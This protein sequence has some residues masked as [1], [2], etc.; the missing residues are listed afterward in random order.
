LL[1]EEV[2]TQTRKQKHIKNYRAQR[3]TAP[4]ANMGNSDPMI[5]FVV[6]LVGFIIYLATLVLSVIGFVTSIVSSTPVLILALVVSSAM[7]PWVEYHAPIVNEMEHFMR[8]VVYPGYEAV[9]RP[10]MNAIRRFYNPTVCF[11]DAYQLW[12]YTMVWDV[13]YPTIAEC[14]GLNSAYLFGQFLFQFFNDFVINY[15]AQLE[16]FNGPFN[17]AATC[18]AWRRF[19]LAF[20]VSYCCSCNDLCEFLIKAPFP[21]SPVSG[22]LADP[23][24]C[25]FA[26]DSLNVLMEVLN[27]W[28]TL[29]WDVL[30][31]LVNWT[32]NIN[33]P[34]MYTA[35]LI[36]TNATIHLSN[37]YEAS[38]Q[39][40]WDEFAPFYAFNFSGVFR[41][42]A[43]YASLWF[44]ALNVVWTIIINMDRIIRYPTDRFWATDMR[45]LI[46]D[47]VNVIAAPTQFPVVAVAPTVISVGFNV[48][49][50]YVSTNSSITPLNQPNVNYQRPRMSDSLCLFLNRTLCNP[51]DPS[52]ACFGTTYA[53]YLQG[54]NPC[55][56]TEFG[57]T[58]V[59]DIISAAYETTVHF[60]SWAHFFTYADQ[61]PFTHAARDSIVNGAS[62]LLQVLRFIPQGYGM[63]LQNLLTRAVQWYI[64][65]LDF[66]VHM[67]TGIITL[68]YYLT[69]LPGTD[70]Y[71]TNYTEAITE[72]ARIQATLVDE[73]DPTSFMNSMCYLLNNALPVPPIPCT[74]CRVT[75]FLPVN[76]SFSIP[77]QGSTA[78]RKRHDTV[79]AMLGMPRELRDQ[80]HR[81][82]PLIHYGRDYPTNPWDIGHMLWLNSK[83]LMANG[84]LPFPTHDTINRYFD[85]KRAAIAERWNRV[86]RCKEA[87]RVEWTLHEQRPHEWMAR[88]QRGDFKCDPDESVHETRTQF[89]YVDYIPG[90][91]PLIYENCTSPVPP[92]YDFCCFPRSL[93]QAYVSVITLIANSVNGIIQY[94]P[95]FQLPVPTTSEFPYF[96]GELCRAPWNQAC[97]QTDIINAATRVFRVYYCVCNFVTLM[98]PIV[99]RGREQPRICETILALANFAASAVQVATNTLMCV[100]LGGTDSPQQYAYFARGLFNNDIN[101]LADYADEV[102][103]RVADL[104]RDV[105][106]FVNADNIDT[107]CAPSVV[108]VTIVETMRLIS[109]SIA[110]LGTMF[111][112]TAQSNTNLPAECWFRLD[113]TKG[114]PGTLDQIGIIRQFDIVLDV[115]LPDTATQ[116]CRKSCNGADPGIGGITTCVCQVVNTLLPWRNDPNKPISCQAPLNCMD[117]DFCCP[118][119]K[120]GIALKSI[121][122]F[123][124]RALVA[125]IQPWYDGFPQF[126]TNYIFCSES[127]HDPFNPGANTT[128]TECEVDNQFAP[129]ISKC[130]QTNG[131]TVPCGTFTCAKMDIIIENL[132]N[133]TNGLFACACQYLQILDSL[134]SYYFQL[135]SNN[136]GDCFCGTQYGLIPGALNVLRQIARAALDMIRKSTLACY[137]KPSN[138]VYTFNAVT[139]LC[140]PAAVSNLYDPTNSFIFRILSPIANA[141]CI[142]AGN[143]MCVVNS[144]FFLSPL[145]VEPGARAAGG[146][147]GWMF[148]VFFRLFAFVE[149]FVAQFADEQETCTGEDSTCSSTYGTAIFDDTVGA[150]V[151][152]SILTP[153]LTLPLD[154][155]MADSQIACTTICPRGSSYLKVQPNPCQCYDVAHS[156]RGRYVVSTSPV[157]VTGSVWEPIR[158]FDISGTVFNST[159]RT[160]AIAQ[161]SDITYINRNRYFPDYATYMQDPTFWKIAKP[162]VN[163]S[164]Y[165]CRS[166]QYPDA[167]VV[168]KSSWWSPQYLWNAT[169]GGA[170]VYLPPCIN[171]ADWAWAETGRGVDPRRRSTCNKN[172]LCRPDTLPTCGLSQEDMNSS[173]EEKARD[174]IRALDGIIMSIIRF[175]SCAVSTLTNQQPGEEDFGGP[176]EFSG[177]TSNFLYPFEVFISMAW[178]ILAGFIDVTVA[179]IIFLLSF[180]LAFG[181]DNCE[182]Y[183]STDITQIIQGADAITVTRPDLSTYT[184]TNNGVVGSVIVVG[185]VDYC[186]TCPLGGTK[187]CGCWDSATSIDTKG[188]MPCADHCP[189]YTGSVANCVA[190]LTKLLVT[191][192]NGDATLQALIVPPNS[193]ITD[194]C[195]G[196]RDLGATPVINASQYEFPMYGKSAFCPNPQCGWGANGSVSPIEPVQRPGY[197]Y[198]QDATLDKGPYCC[199]CNYYNAGSQDNKFFQC[200][201]FGIVSAFLD[202]IR[203]FVSIFTRQ[204]WIPDGYAKRDT[205]QNMTFTG[206][207]KRRESW[208][209]MTCRTGIKNRMNHRS[210]EPTDNFM[211]I[212]YEYDT[213]DCFDDPTA[214]ACRNLYLPEICQWHNNAVVVLKDRPRRARTPVDPASGIPAD[215]ITQVI[216]D[217][218]TG[219]SLCDHIARDMAGN[220]WANTSYHH[221]IQ[222]V[223][224]LDQ[225]IQ[226]ERISALRPDI[227]PT[228]VIYARNAPFVIFNNIRNSVVHHY[229][230]RHDR[231]RFKRK[232]ARQNRAATHKFA[233]LRQDVK[234]RRAIMAHALKEQL[235]HDSP[236]FQSLL[237]LDSI[238]YKY[239]RGYY[240]YLYDKLVKRIEKRQISFPTVIEAKAHLDNTI[241]EFTRTVSL[242]PYRELFTA[243]VNS[244][245]IAGHTVRDALVAGPVQ[246]VRDAYASVTT[247]LYVSA[248]RRRDAKNAVIQRYLDQTPLYA[249]IT[250][251]TPPA[252]PAAQG[253]SFTRFRTHLNRVIEH[254]RNES[255]RAQLS[256]WNADLHVS[257]WKQHVTHMFTPQL[258]PY[259]TANWHKLKRVGY[260]MYNIVFPGSLTR[261]QHERFIFGSTCILLQRTEQVTVALLSYCVNEFAN[262]VNVTANGRLLNFA[263]SMVEHNENTFHHKRN[264][265]RYELITPTDPHAWSRYRF[266]DS[267]VQRER[268]PRHSID[269][270]VI[271]RTIQPPQQ[272]GPAN[273]NFYTWIWILLQDFISATFGIPA[274]TFLDDVRNWLLNPKTAEADYPNVGLRYWTVFWFR[275]RW[276]DNLNCSKGIGILPAFW[277]VTLGVAIAVFFG[278]RIVP[279][280]LWIVAIFG[281]FFLWIM[282][283]GAVGIHYSPACLRLYPNFNDFDGMPLGS[284]GLGFNM[285]LPMCLADAVMNLTDTY[286]TNCYSPLIIP[287]YMISG[288]LCPTSSDQYIDFISCKTV[289]VSDGI[290]NVLYICYTYLGG[291]AL[292]VITAIANVTI[293]LF[294][295]GVN[296]YFQLTI[297]GFRTASAVQQQREWFCFF[298]TLP[299]IALPGVFV[300]LGGCFIGF[301]LPF[302]L[303]L[304]FQIWSLLETTPVVNALPG[305]DGSFDEDDVDLVPIDF[306][307]VPREAITAESVARWI[308]FQNSQAEVGLYRF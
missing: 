241:E 81:V 271:K 300:F 156:T 72:F 158:V 87:K 151:L 260:Q 202:L 232:L 173:P 7:L 308:R 185:A 120:A 172:G 145:C 170:G 238:A 226:G 295:P 117:I 103:D 272:D 39:L 114:C 168:A 266:I 1:P 56:L 252:A 195:Q 251:S 288:P 213:T 36:A 292:D 8:T 68:P 191:N 276:P 237:G 163:V 64:S 144:L 229:T 69:T 119:V 70:N 296:T 291:W 284:L 43:D 285:A 278:S 178:Q 282:L 289:G 184:Y 59:S 177:G 262:N 174:P 254:N 63:A 298:F 71:A 259:K 180:L 214:C 258:T 83:D 35:T 166:I 92:C 206:P 141:M 13:I 196:T 179:L 65:M 94:N 132:V 140:Q 287:P 283:I 108:G 135:V 264:I 290:Q 34:D 194:A 10:I 28:F 236:L 147:I 124:S 60:D 248:S 171:A 95:L 277:W 198:H 111:I 239:Q 25:A 100:L 307:N 164:E 4:P 222:W 93:L 127:V 246:Y 275:C 125:L 273:Y 253:W 293:G 304:L 5:S 24:M 47:I 230:E 88:K 31:S 203:A 77:P 181:A 21:L 73:E 6:Q 162:G 200:G 286:I 82:T 112:P 22:Q 209:D 235:A 161:M 240:G 153:L 216:A 78:A 80:S 207:A 113:T 74:S 122:K 9:A 75:G 12:G 301:V 17:Y 231:T 106:P 150:N 55:C 27:V 299:A 257:V 11:V 97:I 136:W 224:C 30:S 210:P 139:G 197:W 38:F 52:T 228:N 250:G 20:E 247:Q 242:Q 41:V 102:V 84:S 189:Y 306:K 29:V 109:L 44:K 131:T 186:Y 16:F 50:Y 245:V 154:M 199:G 118:V 280:F 104:V 116:G 76:S 133:P 303:L 130:W 243:S 160:A 23:E 15:F 126:F 263:R 217:R 269:H 220:A 19:F 89:E 14:E 267:G 149:G 85:K 218:F 193:T 157:R 234:D 45:Y 115:L 123:A 62:C 143:L 305:Y 49:N 201:V 57:G 190:I 105:F 227:I 91:I 33:R 256:A 128:C 96:T 223:D 270:R 107:G 219:E 137:W 294:V 40:F 268:D 2:K 58:L 66:V 188:W 187:S 279:S 129:P 79:Q 167:S 51:N 255:S 86:H 48:T 204:Y 146:V 159:E 249:W 148:T 110:S 67:A 134:L 169:G 32:W 192:Q 165:V 121:G 3:S 98:I 61:Q 302:A 225:R 215:E 274:N 155:Y 18:A 101:Q 54:I 142:S 208:F 42:F 176:L 183:G 261:Q 221:K 37:A 297:Q 281:T 205:A 99:A 175:M 53:Q 211:S 26:G 46:S 90:P 152:A 138:A 212:F 182:C 244:M 265:A 233:G